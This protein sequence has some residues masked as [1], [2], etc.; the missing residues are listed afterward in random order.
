ML[1]PG[2]QANQGIW[3]D[4]SVWGPPSVVIAVL[5]CPQKQLLTTQAILG[6]NRMNRQVAARL[7]Q[8]M[9]AWDLSQKVV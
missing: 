3:Y 4:L 5:A 6:Q 2:A 9:T 8:P 7:M 1:V